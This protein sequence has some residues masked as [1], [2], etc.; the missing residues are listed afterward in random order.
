VEVRR[1]IQE[2]KGSRFVSE[3]GGVVIDTSPRG[4]LYEVR[5]PEDD[6]ERIARCVQVQ[7]TSTPRQYF[8]RVPPT[9]PDGNRSGGLELRAVR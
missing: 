9:I 6:P 2:R 8:V 1:V 7:D 5:L 4:T 3:L